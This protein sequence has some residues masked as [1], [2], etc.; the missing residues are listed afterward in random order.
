MIGLGS[1]NNSGLISGMRDIINKTFLVVVDKIQEESESESRLTRFKVS[2]SATL[3]LL[4]KL[5]LGRH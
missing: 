2:L 5:I 3:A 4:S 1:D